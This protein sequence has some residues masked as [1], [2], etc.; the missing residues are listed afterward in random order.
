MSRVGILTFL[1]NENYG[2]SLQAYALQRVVRSLGHEVEHLDYCPDQKEKIRN[3][4][5]SGNS[6]KLILDGIRKRR[7]GTGQ[8]S[9]RSKKRAI[10]DFYARRMRLSP[11]CRNRKELEGAS[12]RYSVLLCGSDQIWNPVWL[13]PV[14]FLNF[15]GKKIRRIAYAP[16]LGVREMPPGKKIR[17]MRKLISGFQAVSVREEE[18]ADLLERITGMRPAV[19]PDPVCLL[20][21]EQWRE[22]AGPQP[23][24]TPYLLCYFIGENPLYWEKAEQAARERGL[25]I[26]T[27]PVTGRHMGNRLSGSKDADR[28]PSWPQSTERE[29]FAQTASTALYSERSFKKTLFFAEGI[30][31]M[32]RKTK[33]A[34]S[35]IFGAPSPGKGFRPYGR[36]GCCGCGIV[37]RNKGARERSDESKETGQNIRRKRKARLFAQT[38]GLFSPWKLTLLP[39]CGSW[40]ERAAHCHCGGSGYTRSSDG[41]NR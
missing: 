4:I 26:L 16:S 37:W 20:T 18:G 3:M 19:L 28:R 9:A 10:A 15:G 29:R 12:G 31:R 17:R 32:I 7:V 36:K 39:Q 38:G 13:N 24:G 2:S 1:H 27:I 40:G 35:I 5:L 34:G 21:A 6:P 11:L 41:R 25:R 22:T 23:G 14:Y 33:T 30:G 8:E